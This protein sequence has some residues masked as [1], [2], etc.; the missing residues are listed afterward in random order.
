MISAIFKGKCQMW[1]TQCNVWS[2]ILDFVCFNFWLPG[3]MYRNFL[4]DVKVK[5]RTTKVS[6]YGLLIVVLLYLAVFFYHQ[7]ILFLSDSLSVSDT[8]HQYCHFLKVCR[9]SNVRQLIIWQW[10]S[11]RLSD[12]TLSSVNNTLC[13]LFLLLLLGTLYIQYRMLLHVSYLQSNALVS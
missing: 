12:V 9:Q 7:W 10:N 4:P 11:N 2:F 13:G 8:H 6:I 1:K 5:S 3:H